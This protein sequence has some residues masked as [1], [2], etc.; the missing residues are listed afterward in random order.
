MDGRPP[1]Q[2][3]ERTSEVIH[4]I[5]TDKLKRKLEGKVDEYSIENVS[6]SIGQLRFSG[7]EKDVYNEWNEA[8]ASIFASIGK[9]EAE[10]T[11]ESDEDIEEAIEKLVK[12]IKMSP[13]NDLYGGLNPE[14]QV[15]RIARQHAVE[16]DIEEDARQLISGSMDSGSDRVSGLIY[17]RHETYDIITS[18]NSGSFSRYGMEYLI[19]TFKGSRTGQESYQSAS[20]TEYKPYD[21]GKES[22]ESVNEGIKIREGDEGKFDVIFSPYSLG[23]IMTYGSAFFSAYSVLAGLSCF[24]DRIGSKIS[25]YGLNLYD[26]PTD[27]M[28][29]GY[30]PI[31]DEGTAT[32]KKAIISDGRLET[33]LQSYSTAKKLSSKTTGNAGIISPGAFQ[34]S[35]DPGKTDLADMISGM[36]NGLIINN[37]WYLRFQDERNGLFSTV[38]RDGVYHVV[39][40][41]IE[42]AWGGIRVSESFPGLIMRMDDVSKER[43]R[44]K[45]W[46]EIMPSVLPFVKI[47]D[48]NISRAF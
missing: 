30:R 38:P 37:S 18:Y 13:E 32:R 3:Q 28:G 11:V 36:K 47:S 26:D 42:E 10:I 15:Y 45:W 40:G 19:R 1:H 22:A 14:K 25:G 23:N 6:A 46:N 7:K 20:A 31:D 33:Y 12:I 21:I 2:A 8:N 48:V 24:T 5:D 16:T 35:M 27:E 44:I 34:L 17:R 4:M 41:R 43:K 39:N 9:K 29:I